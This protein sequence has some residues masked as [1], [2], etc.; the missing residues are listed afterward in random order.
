MSNFL[1]L[2]LILGLLGFGTTMMGC[3]DD[4]K[5]DEKSEEKETKSEEKGLSVTEACESAMKNLAEEEGMSVA[6]IAE[7]EWNE[8][9]KNAKR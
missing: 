6:D 4:S 1:R 7:E 3:G 5:S 9:M 8:A 2:S